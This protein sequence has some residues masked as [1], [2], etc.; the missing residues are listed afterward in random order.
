LVDENLF[1]GSLKVTGNGGGVTVTNNTV[2]GSLT[3]T[4]NSGAVV[5]APNE[6]EGRSKLQ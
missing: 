3:V 1:Y 2:A 5:D 4:G 6:V